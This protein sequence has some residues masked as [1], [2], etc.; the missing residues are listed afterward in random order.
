MNRT[1]N[2][3]RRIGFAETAIVSQKEALHSLID[4]VNEAHIRAFDE[5]V[6]HTFD[7][8]DV[9]YLHERAG[10]MYWWKTHPTNPISTILLGGEQ[11]KYGIEIP[12]EVQRIRVNKYGVNAFFD[13]VEERVESDPSSV[14]LAS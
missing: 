4:P 7:N 8:G 1:R 6:I 2:E 5:S 9:A 11:L 12:G 13:L 3:T 10:I 14:T